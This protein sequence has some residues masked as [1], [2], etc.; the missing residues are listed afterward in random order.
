MPNRSSGVAN[1]IREN[2]HPLV[3]A[4]SDYDPLIQQIGDAR[5]VLIGEASHGT[6]DFYRE[7]GPT[8]SRFSRPPI[9]PSITRHRVGDRSR[10]RQ[11][12][13]FPDRSADRQQPLR[14][15][16]GRRSA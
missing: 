4:A 14:K 3:G 9:S 6:H 12:G 8:E 5:F 10:A 7:R 1:L 2:L 15:R 13:Y 11:I 16:C